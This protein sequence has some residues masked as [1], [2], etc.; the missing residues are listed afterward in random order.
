MTM[1]TSFLGMHE[2]SAAGS[3]VLFQERCKE[4]AKEQQLP[5]DDLRKL[6]RLDLGYSSTQQLVDWIFYGP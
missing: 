1:L 6:R 3:M 4:C 5:L 2:C